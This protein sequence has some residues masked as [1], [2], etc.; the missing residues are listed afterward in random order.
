MLDKDTYLSSRIP[1]KYYK[2]H[3][4]MSK[5]ESAVAAMPNEGIIISNSIRSSGFAIRLCLVVGFVIR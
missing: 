4:N 5:N 3:S 2:N 1:A